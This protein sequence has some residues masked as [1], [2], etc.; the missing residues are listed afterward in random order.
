MLSTRFA[1]TAP[2]V[3]ISAV[4]LAG[5]ATPAR[6]QIGGAARSFPDSGSKILV[7]SDQLPNANDLTSA[8]WNFIATHYVGSQKAVRSWTQYVRT[9]N[10]NYIMLHYQLALGNSTAP[11]VD[12]N[13]WV[14]DFSFVTQHE[15]WFLHD[16]QKNRI[17]QSYWQWYVMNIVFNAK[18]FPKSYYPTY[19]TQAAIKRLRDNLNDGVFAD[20]YTVDVLVDQVTPAYFWFTDV[21]ACLQYW[22]PNL[23]KYGAFCAAALHGQPEKFYYL[24]N[25][26]GLITS[27]DQTNY[28][29][30]DGGMNEGFAIPDSTSYYYIGDWQL[31]MSRMLQLTSQRKIMIC[32]SYIN[33]SD[34][35]QRWFVVGSQLLTKGHSSYLNMFQDTTFSWFPEYDIPLGAYTEEPQ[36]DL[37]HYWNAAWGV[38][39]RDFANGIVLVNPGTTAVSIQL[40][41]AYNL[42]TASGGGPIGAN[43]VSSGSLQTA[44]VQQVT[45]PAHSARVLLY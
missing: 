44:S 37:S 9:L 19:W 2:I 36:P 17:E 32:Q 5:T 33:A 23:N 45:I 10:P 28:A 11:Y 14:N 26:G 34:Y 8:Q 21:N 6:A 29:V 30:G 15:A 3:L 38:Y 18:G 39:E 1:I 22:I 7:F 12:G 43:G 4:L 25:L 16:N 20:S 31:Q 24:P 13:N 41:R 27:W 40:P 42:V 35:N